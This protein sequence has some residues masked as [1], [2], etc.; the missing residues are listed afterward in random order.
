[1]KY[2]YIVKNNALEGIGKPRLQGAIAA[3]TVLVSA[4][5]LKTSSD[6][7]GMVCRAVGKSENGTA[8]TQPQGTALRNLKKLHS[9]AAGSHHDQPSVPQRNRNFNPEVSHV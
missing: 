2:S 5:S 1:M 3:G 6:L 7:L 9:F 8:R 4:G